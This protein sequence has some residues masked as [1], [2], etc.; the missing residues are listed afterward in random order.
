VASPDQGVQFL[1]AQ[2]RHEGKRTRA[3]GQAEVTA[4]AGFSA[5]DYLIIES[6]AFAAS[7]RCSMSK[8][9]DVSEK[10]ASEQVSDGRQH[11]AMIVTIP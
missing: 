7:S 4:L 11:L 8:T 1:V 10:M 3:S 5:P 2:F 9:V 6:A